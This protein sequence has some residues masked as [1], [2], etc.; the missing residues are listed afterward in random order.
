[1]KERLGNENPFGAGTSRED[2]VAGDFF[3]EG[4][5]GGFISE[6]GFRSVEKWVVAAVVWRVGSFFVIY[7]LYALRGGN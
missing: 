3:R 4:I 5:F 2:I 6:I 1:M 7:P